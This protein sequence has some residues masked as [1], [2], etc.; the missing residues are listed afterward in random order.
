LLVAAFFG[1]GK[2]LPPGRD[3]RAHYILFIVPA[4]KRDDARRRGHKPRE[5]ARR[6]VFFLANPPFCDIYPLAQIARACGR[7]SAGANRISTQ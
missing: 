4:E 3:G 7:A 2:V 1:F 6:D 5:T